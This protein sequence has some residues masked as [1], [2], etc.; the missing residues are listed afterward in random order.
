MNVAIF[1]KILESFQA[2]DK[3]LNDSHAFEYIVTNV[4]QNMEAVWPIPLFL[5]FLEN[6]SKSSQL[7]MLI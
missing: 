1:L 7:N 4:G 3:L 5:R 2:D 6:P